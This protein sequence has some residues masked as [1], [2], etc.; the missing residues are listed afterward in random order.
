[1]KKRNK[2]KMA[3]I[4]YLDLIPEK[5]SSLKWHTDLKERVILEVE[6]TGIMNKIA[7]NLFNKPRFTKVHLDANGSFIW[8]LIDGKRTVEDIA[9]LV[10]EQF[11]EAAEPLYPRIIKYFQIVESYH[12]IRF[13]NMPEK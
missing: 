11:G 3:D 12:F 4:N 8:P 9:V 6:N 10:K 1:M 13:V 7:Q 5:S 2:K